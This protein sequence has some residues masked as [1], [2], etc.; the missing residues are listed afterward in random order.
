MVARKRTPLPETDPDTGA[1]MLSTFDL[2][3]RG[4]TPAMIRD[5]LGPHDAT[6][7]NQMRFGRRKGRAA[8]VK[9]YR[10][11]RVDD[12]EST[13]GFLVAQ[14]R[15]MEA[16]ERAE[17]AADTRR[18]NQATRIEAL[19]ERFQI[20]I[21]AQPGVRPSKTARQRLIRAHQQPVL[22]TERWAAQH[23]HL[24]KQEQITLRVRLMER[25]LAALEEAYPWMAN[26]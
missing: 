3:G 21:A 24:S 8:P 19:I 5:L 13:E 17:R 18:A 14:H 16:R 9:L 22:D 26:V 7:P 6:R 1:E 12:T 20:D 23:L 4:W 15:A 11:D 25:Y 10:R 2:K